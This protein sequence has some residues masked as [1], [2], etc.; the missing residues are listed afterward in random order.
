MPVAREIVISGVGVLSPIGT[1]RAEMWSS[2]VARE[3]GV[4]RLSAF[5]A[6][7]LPVQIGGEI[8]NFDGKAYVPVKK[9]LKVM[10][11]E[12]QLGVSVARMAVKDAALDPT[13]VDPERFGVICG[14]DLMQD[15]IPDITPLYQACIADGKFDFAPWGRVMGQHVFPLFM[16]KYLPNMAACHMAIAFDALGPN[17]TV[18]MGGASSLLAILE[19]VRVIERGAA[20]VMLAGGAGTRIQPLKYVQSCVGADLSRRNDDPARAMRPFDRDRDGYVNGEG[21][22]IFVL[23]TRAHAE[24]RGAKILARVC[25][26]GRAAESRGAHQPLTGS[27]LARAMRAALADAGWQRSDVGHVNADGL[28]TRA[29][30]VAEAGAIAETLG[31]VPVTAPKS[32]FGFLGAGS[33]AVELAASIAGFEQGLVPPTLNYRTPDAACPL[34]VVCDEPRSG[35]AAERVLAVNQSFAGQAVALAIEKA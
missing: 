20:D 4:R 17:N 3:S 28:S 1:S 12:I 2:I 15:A 29:A 32:Y 13:Q 19:A 27:A 25:G 22:A 33:G 30:D 18:T 35:R 7:A 11:R 6:S 31:P 21:G 14:A 10:N 8:P 16:L 26:G 23:E 24:S 9:S 34:D 5:D